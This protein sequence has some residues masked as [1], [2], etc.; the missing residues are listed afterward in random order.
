MRALVVLVGVLVLGVV[1]A[2]LYLTSDAGSERVRSL[3]LGAAGDALAGKLEAKK[4]S[5][6]GGLI[7]LEDLKLYTPEGELVA[8]LKR[9]EL[10]VALGRL[11][12]RDVVVKRADVTGLRLY[13]ASDERGLNLSRAIA[14]KTPAPK[15]DEPAA[16]HVDVQQLKLTGGHVDWQQE[17]TLDDISIAG[18]VDVRSGETLKLDGKLKVTGSLLGETPLPLSLDVLAKEQL[19]GV[20]LSLGEAR[21]DGD[22]SLADTAAR[23]AELFV[24]PSVAARFVEEFP[25]VVPVKASGTASPASIDLKVEAGTARVSAKASLAGAAVPSFEVK[26]EDVNVAELLG[27]GRP[28]DISLDARGSLSD[29]KLET[30]GGALKLDAKWSSVGTLNVDATANGGELVI[31]NLDLDVRGA[32]LKASGR[33]TAAK[34]DV[35]ATLDAEDLSQLAKVLGEVT[36]SPPMDLAGTGKLSARV[37]GPLKHPGLTANGELQA[38]HLGG[39]SLHAVKLDLGLEDV[40][41]P[42]EARLDAEVRRI[43]S[44]ER[45]FDDVRAHLDTH[46]RD[47][48]LLL[49]TKG[50]ADMSLLAKG[51]VDDDGTGVQLTGLTL[52]YPEADWTLEAP[53]HV[54]FGG[55]LDVEALTLL[56]TDARVTLRAALKGGKI[57]ALVDAKN[58][59]LTHLP[60]AFVPTK[61][62]LGGKLDLKATATGRSAAPVAEASVAWR[63]GSVRT[64]RQLQLALEA[65]YEK[66]RASGSLDGS[67][68]MGALKGSFDVPVKGLTSGKSTEPLSADVA[69]TGL[70]LEA[71]GP[72]AGADIPA[73]G[74]ASIRLTASGTASK[75]RVTARVEATDAV[76]ELKERGGDRFIPVDKVV[77]EVKPD[78]EGALG[79]TLEARAFGAE[80]TVT[81]LTPL[82]LEGV[83]SK[84]PTAESLRATEVQLEAKVQRLQLEA[85]EGANLLVSDLKGA[86]SLQLTAKGSVDHPAVDGTVTLQQLEGPRLKPVDATLRLIAQG[87]QTK[88]E[89]AARRGSVRLVELQMTAEAPLEKLVDTKHLSAVPFK[90]GGDLGPFTLDDLMKPNPDETQPRGSV[91]ADVEL[92][93]TLLDPSVRL[94]GQLEEVAMGKVAIGKANIAYDYE[95]A[96]STLAMTLFTGAGQ[97]RAKGTVK[98]DLSEPAVVK[99][100]Q[101]NQA[102]VELELQSQGLDLAFLSGVVEAVPR[103]EGKLDANA[104]LSGTIGVPRFSGDIL[105]KGGRVAAQGFGEYREIEVHATGT[106]DA[107]KLEKLFAKSGGGWASVYGWGTRR[108][109]GWHFKLGGETKDFP[110]IADDQLKASASID[111]V[112]AEG[113]FAA[114]LIDVR[115]LSIERVV[116]ELPEVKGKDLQDLERPETIVLVRNGVPVSKGQRKKLAKLEGRAA[117]PEKAPARTMRI[118]VD[119]PKNL[120]VKSSDVNAEAGLSENFRVEVSEV[121]SMF[122]E[123]KVKRG[124]LDVLGRRFDVDPSSAVRFAGL[125]TRAYV[126]VTATHRNEREDVTVF[127]TVVGQMPQF[128]IRMTSNPP[129]S[130]SDI[131]ALV[132]TG[133]RTLKQGGSAAITNDQVASVLGALAASQLKGALGKKLPLDVLSIETG[134][135]GLRGTRVEGGKYLTDQVYLGVEARYGADPRKGE[136][137]V[138]AKVEYQFIPHW[139]VEAYGGNAA[140]G[141]DLVWGREF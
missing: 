121:V 22:L 122:G 123:V 13:L 68:S 6:K 38:L 60:H 129:M 72:L 124:R 94:R 54:S 14:A 27:K 89:L 90:G 9:A 91:K 88:V 128:N 25:L 117:E 34:V 108:S 21:L 115:R 48:D 71:L 118:T 33:G 138:A 114:E 125:P 107:A 17:Y 44:G 132:A 50:H 93:G 43:T 31:S 35:R 113:L 136:N 51:T 15:S 37:Q 106:Q 130:E 47:L 30:L 2:W 57:D 95:D 65:R 134:S 52:H 84:P 41:Q 109:D 67:S 59:E 97:L 111:H 70:V 78:D 64:L 63:N 102:P 80:A 116:I 49:S 76:W 39:I 42:L 131:F 140:Y 10:D 46:G 87:G 55:G 105:L 4:L 16:L 74:S 104:K 19:L 20:K 120:W 83:R 7:V 101:P 127:A 62:G 79:A 23:I 53:A 110:I 77:L 5:L 32:S 135:D 85:L 96:L 100:L 75:P 61:W 103:V 141:A 45:N 137:D 1:G 18:G 86:V 40:T 24:P 56:S 11:V 126:N 69:L 3:A 81:V 58:V 73:K 12:S 92:S 29:A 119:A 133:R 36:G 8:E 82:T 98:L 139:T 26:A 28:S 112:T 99:G 66:D